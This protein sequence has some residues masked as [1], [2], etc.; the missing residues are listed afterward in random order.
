HRVSLRKVAPGLATGRIEILRHQAKVIAGL[1][2]LLELLPRLVATADSC[3]RI[4]TPECAN[5]ERGLGFA[6]IVGFL[7]AQQM[8]TC[9]QDLLD[10]LDSCYKSRIARLQESNLTHEQHAGIQMG[11]V[12]AFDKCPAFVRPGPR[13]DRIANDARALGP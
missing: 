7:V 4:Q 12:E 2:Q 5:I 6:E 11:A 9:S 10:P 1:K 8:R 3:Q 13:Q